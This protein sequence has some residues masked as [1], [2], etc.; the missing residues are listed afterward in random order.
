VL[1]ARNIAA[2][3]RTAYL[4]LQEIVVQLTQKEVNYMLAGQFELLAAKQE[5]YNIYQDYLE[6]LRNYWV[7]RSALKR[8]VGADLPSSSNPGGESVGPIELPDTPAPNTP[9]IDH[10]THS[11]EMQGDQQ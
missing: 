11:Y 4:P 6:S 9:A 7:A 10:R 5:E 3:Y 8:A 1:A 2:H